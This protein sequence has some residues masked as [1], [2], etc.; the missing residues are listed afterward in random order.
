MPRTK[1]NEKKDSLSGTDLIA[2]YR[3]EPDRFLPMIVPAGKQGGKN[4]YG[5]T[6]IGW[7]AG[8]LPDGRPFFVECW[9]ADGASYLTFYLSAR[10][11]ERCSG[12]EILQMVQK[13]GYLQLR[14]SGGETAEAETFTDP[15]GE[16]FFSVTITVGLEEEPARIQGAP[17][18]PWSVLNESYAAAQR[19]PE[20]ATEA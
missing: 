6:D 15:K 2:A 17:I 11:I 20:E 1:P 3:S 9:A 7:N 4:E 19:N 18:L 16:A 10:G 8:L 13:A 14:K 12:D 5:E